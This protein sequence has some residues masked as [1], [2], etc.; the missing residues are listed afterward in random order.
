MSIPTRAC[1]SSD[2]SDDGVG[3][4]AM[5]ATSARRPSRVSQTS[6]AAINT[7]QGKATTAVNSGTTAEV[8]EGAGVDA[9]AIELT[10]Q[11]T[12]LVST[13][14]ATSNTVAG[15]TTSRAEARVN[16]A[17]QTL[18]RVA[19]GADLT[20][21]DSIDI[22]S[23]QESAQ[24]HANATAKT[25]GFSGNLTAIAENDTDL[26][27]DVVIESG[28]VLTTTDL[29]IKA[30]T[31]RSSEVYGRSA[32]AEGATVVNVVIT[33]IN[34]V[35][36]AF[37]W[38][39]FIG[40]LVR[41]ITRQVTQV[42]R[43]VTNSN[44]STQ[45]LGNLQNDNSIRFDGEIHQ[46]GARTRLT[47]NPD[48]SI[49]TIGGISARGGW[50]HRR[51]RR[52]QRR[53]AGP[54]HLQAPSGTV[55]GTGRI[56]VNNVFDHVTIVNNS[57]LDLVVNDIIVGSNNAGEPNIRIIADTQQPFETRGETGS[58]TRITVAANS[59]ADII[60]SGEVLNGSGAVDVTAEDGSIYADQGSLLEVNGLELAADN[61]SIGTAEERVPVHLVSD[62]G[63]ANPHIGALA[64]G[65]I[66]LD[67]RLVSF[68]GEPVPAGFSLSGGEFGNFLA[69]GDI[70]ILARPGGVF[71][72]PP[73]I[74]ENPDDGIIPPPSPVQ[75]I[76]VDATYNFVGELM[77]GGRISVDAAGSV[78]DI[79]GSLTSGFAD[80]D[81][82]LGAGGRDTLASLDW[83]DEV[84]DDSVSLDEFAP[85]GGY[86]EI[87]ANEVT[88]TGS[89]DVLSGYTHVSVSSSSD[90]DLIL[91]RIGID[92]P[93]AG[94]I[95]V[96]GASVDR[97]K[98]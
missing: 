95:L 32:D 43:T 97:R 21:T 84:T 54:G 70:D 39:P 86:V 94:T 87:Q 55:D 30:E 8:L 45:L 76:E 60:F 10:A 7:N 53:P 22:T 6:V 92:A 72:Q 74:D 27:A 85:Q 49:V 20:A 17:V 4:M 1:S 14:D 98:A 31:P 25:I 34:V 5:T 77:A 47:I 75:D 80:L 67:T 51:R 81:I 2:E 23:L 52:D 42:I 89:I 66:Y 48:G 3:E 93:G 19:S 24:T 26:D 58:G 28:A 78:V 63:L 91:P 35:T 96:N 12:R 9:R 82:D 13:A 41:W 62:P 88:G 65:S 37:S 44:E 71:Y 50:P 33:Q 68:S 11:Q 56:Y 59:T 36:R 40:S 83:T 69:G 73:V 46:F 29:H 64:N 57:P 61:G 18:V 16:N 90:R 38:I 15:G 79:S